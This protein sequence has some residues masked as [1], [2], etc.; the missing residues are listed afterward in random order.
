MSLDADR[1][2]LSELPEFV[3]CIVCHDGALEPYTVCAKEHVLCGLCLFQLEDHQVDNTALCPLCY[4]PIRPQFSEGRKRAVMGLEVFCNKKEEGCEWRGCYS[5]EKKHRE[6]QCIYRLVRCRRCSAHVADKDWA[7]HRDVCP[8]MLITCERGGPNCGGIKDNGWF[9]RRE[10]AAHKERCAEFTCRYACG[11]RTTLRNLPA[12]EQHCLSTRT[13]LETSQ[14]EMAASTTLLAQRTNQVHKLQ[15]SEATLRQNLQ[16]HQS[17]IKHLFASKRA[18]SQAAQSG[19]HGPK[20][21]LAPG[22]AALQPAS[23]PSDLQLTDDPIQ[24]ADD[25][26]V[27]DY[28][29]YDGLTFPGHG[30]SKFSSSS[31]SKPKPSISAQPRSIDA[32]LV[33]KPPRK[34]RTKDVLGEDAP[35]RASTSKEQLPPAAPKN[36][37]A[38]RSAPN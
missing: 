29:A 5:D 17:V 6:D 25:P 9:F 37:A 30:P 36:K 27:I 13:A 23:P 26:P 28:A 24:S 32:P 20:P 14:A 7:E 34:K 12:H 4:V 31:S 19:Q 18:A 10:S 38:R 33:P 3:T 15:Q 1:F 8:D 21:E 16:S 35:S 2:V 11:T 22:K